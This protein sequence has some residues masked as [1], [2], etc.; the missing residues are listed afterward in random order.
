M[1]KWPPRLLKL[2]ALE[3]INKLLAASPDLIEERYQRACLLDELGRT[4]EAKSEFW[5]VLKKA[6]T[7][8][9]ALTR[10]GNTLYA[11]GFIAAA[12]TIYRDTVIKHP[13]NPIGYVN[14]ANVLAQIK[15][16]EH[17]R[18]NFEAALRLDP[19][20][21]AANRGMAYLLTDSRDEQNAKRYRDK[22][23]RQ[24]PVLIWPYNGEDLPVN[25]LLLVSALGGMVRLRH[26]FDSHLFQ[27]TVLFVEYFDPYQP[28]PPHQKVVN[29]I[30]DADL[31]RPA[32]EIAAKLLEKTSTIV[33]NHPSRVIQTGRQEILKKLGT[34][35][36]VITP[37]TSFVSRDPLMSPQVGS[38]LNELGF[39]FPFLLRSTGFH[40]GRHFI[41]V[42]NEE[43]LKN[44]LPN[45]PG[46]NLLAIQYLD[47]RS[48]DGKIRKY[49]V[50]MIDGKL[51][52]LHAA[53]SH[54][55]K[56]HFFSA[57]MA[58]NPE[59]REEDLKFLNQMPEVLGKPAI[60][61]LGKICSSLGL[62]YAGVDFSLNDKGDIL[63]FE[64]NATM[65]VNPPDRDQR[66]DYRR[67]AVQKIL[68][69]IQ[70]IL[71]KEDPPTQ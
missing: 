20:N 52:P 66:W 62:D 47:A 38:Y 19:E 25:V 1:N 51:Y 45:L 31:S 65:V 55:W 18:L 41:Y 16:K 46:E 34:I 53:I 5:E 60:E 43:A 11:T 36:G 37:R 71:L 29:A 13:S 6:P 35:P 44:H 67:Q 26:H 33:I 15:E 48:P 57:E 30:G 61:A 21:W 39:S 68:H 27:V 69:A 42:E 3:K 8:F 22:A 17:A 70:Q 4:E 59:N 14:L 32:L 28:L 54:D 10:F 63:L 56:I 2:K 9:G 23:F 7:H 24:K 64:A 50:M 12:L 58:E 49:R 40:E